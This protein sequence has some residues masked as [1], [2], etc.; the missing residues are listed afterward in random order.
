VTAQAAHDASTAGN[1]RARIALDAPLAFGYAITPAPTQIQR[2]TIAPA[3]AANITPA[4]RAGDSLLFV[5]SRGANFNNR[6]A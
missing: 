6:V 5:N 1:L 4:V 3:A 2:V